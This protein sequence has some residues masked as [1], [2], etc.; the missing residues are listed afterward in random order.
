ML[1]IARAYTPGH[2]FWM[3]SVILAGER[4]KRC[5]MWEAG[6]TCRG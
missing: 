3:N 5:K 1:E 4:E 2:L 6:N